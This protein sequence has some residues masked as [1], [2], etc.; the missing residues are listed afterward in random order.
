KTGQT[1]VSKEQKVKALFDDVASLSSTS[2]DFLQANGSNI[3]RLSRQGQAQLPLYAEYSPEYPCLLE[4]MVN[5]I[6]HMEQT[7]RG[8]TLHITL[9]TLPNMPTGYT[10]ADS[11]VYDAHNGPHCSMLPNPPYSQA[12]PGPQPPVHAVHD[13]VQGSHGKFR[14]RPATSFDETS[15][16][17]GTAAERSVVDRLVGPVM[18]VSPARVPDVA[19][20]LFAPLARGSEVSVG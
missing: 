14:P 18:G 9:E 2:R 5:W 3:I 8:F 11:P 6:P 7:Y 15:G 13:G 17:A 1:F 19:S 20:L 10:P 4:G 12:N 16:Y